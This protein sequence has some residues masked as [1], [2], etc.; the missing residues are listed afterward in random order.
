MTSE[1][2]ELRKVGLKITLPRVKI[3]K[4]LETMSLQNEHVSAEDVYHHLLKRGESIGLPT[5]YRVLAQFESA[6]LVVRRHLFKGRSVFELASDDHHD[7]IV[8]L[9]SSE[10]IEFRDHIIE[11]RQQEIAQQHNVELVDHTLVLYVRKSN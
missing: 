6:G 5:V 9:D 3:F 10:I 2:L 7:H 4:L 8:C 11:R 1:N